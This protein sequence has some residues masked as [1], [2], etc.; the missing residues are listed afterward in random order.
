MSTRQIPQIKQVIRR[1]DIGAC[2]HLARRVGSFDS[3]R[4]ILRLLLEE[5]RKILPEIGGG[6]T[7]S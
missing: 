7:T 6:W 3:D 5:T 4:R 1:V 2:E